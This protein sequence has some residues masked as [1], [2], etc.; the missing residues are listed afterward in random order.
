MITKLYEERLRQDI[1][2]IA[3]ITI[4]T[5]LVI[6]GLATYRAITKSEL[7]SKTIKQIKPLTAELDLDTMEL[8]KTRQVIKQT[9]WNNL[10]PQLPDVLLL[11]GLGASE[12]GQLASPSGELDIES[13]AT[14][15]AN[16]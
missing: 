6:I 4:V 16:L 11:P 15:S 1:F 12:S 7:D 14:E 13:E 10:K 8:I 9:D 5:V 3:V 2:R